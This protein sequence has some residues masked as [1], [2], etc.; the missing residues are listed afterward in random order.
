MQAAFH[1]DLTF[2]SAYPYYYQFT[3]PIM[4][5]E[6]YQPPPSKLNTSYILGE[7]AYNVDALSDLHPNIDTDLLR[8]VADGL[9]NDHIESEDAIRALCQTFQDTYT[10]EN[11]HTQ[12]EPELQQKVLDFINGT[13]AAVL[14]DNDVDTIS[15]QR[16]LRSRWPGLH[17]K[18][19]HVAHARAIVEK[20]K[21]VL[22]NHPIV[23]EDDEKTMIME[24]RISLHDSW[25]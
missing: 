14:A 15:R 12:L 17:K 9:R 11:L 8:Q 22:E 1:H 24:V 25:R 4:I 19:H 3:K 10:F 16:G 7:I 13:P 23:Y 2:K 18:H 5:L 21:G 6:L 20:A